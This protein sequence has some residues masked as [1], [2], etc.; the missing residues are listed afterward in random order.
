MSQPFQRPGVHLQELHRVIGPQELQFLG[1]VGPGAGNQGEVLGHP[2]RHAVDVD[3]GEV[4][5]GL[6]AVQ[7]EEDEQ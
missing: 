6:Q 7:E 1:G 2:R 5:G 3:P 4:A